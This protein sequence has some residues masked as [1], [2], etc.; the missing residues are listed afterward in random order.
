MIET[1]R[2]N[3]RLFDTNDSAF[4]FRLMNEPDWLRFIGDRGINSIDDAVVCI[5]D[6]L[7]ASFAE[8]GIGMY[9]VELKDTRVPV[10]MCGL[11]DRDSIEGIDLGFALLKEYE[12]NGYAYESAAAVMQNVPVELGIEK[13]S[14]I[15]DSENESSIRL[16]E[17]LGFEFLRMV[18]VGDDQEPIKLYETRID[19]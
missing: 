12:G 1:D 9:L 5:R 2:L 19:V 17:K 18:S 16:L 10:G 8:S 11:I 14:A 7:I 15:T 3:L 6:R 13:L 4:V